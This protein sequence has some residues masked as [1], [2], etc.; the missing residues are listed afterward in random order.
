MTDLPNPC[1][2]IKGFREKGRDTYIDDATFKAVWEAA[3]WSIRDAMDLAY[4]TGQRPAD[5]LKLSRTD[6]KDGALW[7]TQNKTGKKLRIVIEGYLAEVIERITNR[8]Y[9]SIIPMAIVVNER[10]ERLSAFALRGRF[11]T[12]KKLAEENASTPEQKKAIKEFQF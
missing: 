1:L 10:G 5:V 3:D 11:K 12:A 8:R 6:I 9:K 2:G 4:L 7:V